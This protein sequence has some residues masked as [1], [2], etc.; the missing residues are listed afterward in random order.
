MQPTLDATGAEGTLSGWRRWTRRNY[1]W[2][3]ALGRGALNGSVVTAGLAHHAHPL[4]A[5]LAE[6]AAAGLQSAVLQISQVN[7]RYALFLCNARSEGRR[8][9]RWASLSALYLAVMKG[10]GLLVGS[11]AAPLAL[12]AAYAKTV[13]FGSAQYPWVAAIALGRQLKLQVPG[14]SGER[15]RFVADLQTMA[16]S[17]GCVCVSALSSV[18]VAGS[19]PSLLV[20]GLV[21]AAYYLVIRSRWDRWLRRGRPRTE[22]L[23]R[24]TF[25][26]TE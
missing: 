13:A 7:E 20:T 6:G 9:A 8:F 12:A 2:L 26:L 25:V 21:G 19:R 5:S 3:L 15:V 14:R 24:R 10:A 4:G 16:V 17:A 23:P 18:G 11:T 1:S 22:S